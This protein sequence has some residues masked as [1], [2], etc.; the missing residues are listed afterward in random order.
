[1]LSGEF[2]LRTQAD[3]IAELVGD[4]LAVNLAA[5]RAILEAVANEEYLKRQDAKGIASLYA[6]TCEQSY[7]LLSI[8]VSADLRLG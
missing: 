4:V 2:P 5:Q 6:S 8:A 1:V 3:Q 7:H